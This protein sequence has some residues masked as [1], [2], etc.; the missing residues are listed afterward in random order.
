MAERIEEH[1]SKTLMWEYI[2]KC[3][4]VMAKLHREFEKSEAECKELKQELE[5]LRNK[6]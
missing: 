1:S 3:R 5:R 6:R 4:F 2:K